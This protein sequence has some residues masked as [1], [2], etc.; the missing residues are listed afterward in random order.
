M[1]MALAATHDP[2]PPTLPS[3]LT[4]GWG[5]RA[6]VCHLHSFSSSFPPPPPPA[7]VPTTQDE[8]KAVEGAAW[9]ELRGGAGCI[10]HTLASNVTAPLTH[11]V[12]SALVS[13]HPSP[14]LLSLLCAAPNSP[15]PLPILHCRERQAQSQHKG[16]EFD[17]RSMV[18][19]VSCRASQ[20]FT[21]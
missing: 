11:A 16:R 17:G 14:P 9:L 8:E 4:V 15:I 6:T 5:T 21:F 1:P 19:I 10:P 2:H 12:K 20:L 3:G 7:S 18:K 13:D